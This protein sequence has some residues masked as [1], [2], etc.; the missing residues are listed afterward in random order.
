MALWSCTRG[1][2]FLKAQLS[3]PC[4]VL[5]TQH[6]SH[7]EEIAVPVAMG[8]HDSL[9]GLDDLRQ[10]GLDGCCCSVDESG[11]WPFSNASP[12]LA[13][14]SLFRSGPSPSGPLS[15]LDNFG[16]TN[17]EGLLSA[18]GTRHVVHVTLEGACGIR[19]EVSFRYPALAE[20][21]NAY[22]D[23]CLHIVS[24]EVCRFECSCCSIP[25]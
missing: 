1:R 11:H 6:R 24:V 23:R 16:P 22:V 17:T 21:T 7:A 20:W 13:Y 5:N 10:H 15:G 4:H 3:A 19:G 25:K 8:Y 14:L 12:C 18:V 2:L 9:R